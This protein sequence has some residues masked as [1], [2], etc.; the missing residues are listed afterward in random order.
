MHLKKALNLKIHHSTW[1]QSELYQFVRQS[2]DITKFLCALLL[3]CKTIYEFSK[4]I[5]SRGNCE[6]NNASSDKLKI[7]KNPDFT[8]P[9]FCETPNNLIPQ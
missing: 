6:E 9:Q 2:P 8:N 4:S 7:R 3:T 5:C 1:F